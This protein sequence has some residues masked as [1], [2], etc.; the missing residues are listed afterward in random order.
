MANFFELSCSCFRIEAKIKTFPYV[1]PVSNIYY[2]L[3]VHK[4]RHFLKLIIKRFCIID[5]V[6]VKKGSRTRSP[7]TLRSRAASSIPWRMST[8]ARSRSSRSPSSIVSQKLDRNIFIILRIIWWFLIWSGSL[9]G[10]ARR[11][12]LKRRSGLLERWRRPG[13]RQTRRLRTTDSIYRLNTV[14]RKKKI[15][16]KFIWIF[17]IFN[18]KVWIN[19]WA[20]KP[21]SAIFIFIKFFLICPDM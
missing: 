14:N 4:K 17:P 9:V 5:G 1:W 7:R 16:K 8:S 2:L 11:V 3:T 13:R 6:F 20:K 18:Q 21:T 19:F 10:H 15:E 12:G